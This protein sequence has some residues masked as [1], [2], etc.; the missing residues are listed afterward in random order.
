MHEYLK[1][2]FPKGG[3]A[4]DRANSLFV[5]S[6]RHAF[7]YSAIIECLCQELKRKR[8]RKRLNPRSQEEQ[9]RRRHG[10]KVSEPR[11]KGYYGEKARWLWKH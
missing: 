11:G 6:H 1:T 10:W 5:P 2:V 8:K 4:G 3:L 9:G 7:I